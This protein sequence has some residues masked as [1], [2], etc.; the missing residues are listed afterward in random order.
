MRLFV[1]NDGADRKTVRTAQDGAVLHGGLVDCLEVL[2]VVFGVFAALEL[3]VIAIVRPFGAL[4]ASPRRDCIRQ[5]LHDLHFALVDA[6]EGMDAF[7]HAGAVPGGQIAAH[8]LVIAPCVMYHD[9]FRRHGLA[10]FIAVVI[11]Q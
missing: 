11:G 5:S 6:Y 10:R 3:D 8:V 2:G 1:V 4:T 9:P 7:F